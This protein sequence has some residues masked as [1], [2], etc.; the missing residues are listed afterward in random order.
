MFWNN[1]MK[2][3]TFSYDD[4]V[5]QDERLL[6]IFNKYNLKCTFNINSGIQTGANRF[7]KNNIP[8]R[9]MN[10]N[11]LKELYKG[12]EIAVHTLTHPH[13]EELDEDTIYNEIMQDKIN[14]ERIFER[15]IRGMA[16]PFGTYNE[17]VIDIIRKCGIEYARTVMD[18]GNFDIQDN[19]MELKATCHHKNKDLMKLAKEFAELKPDKPQLLYVWGHSYE[20]D[21]DDNWKV[22]EEFCEYISGHEDIFYGTNEEVLLERKKL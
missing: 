7:E 16:Y 14:L 19:L 10:I 12:H 8:I 18:A 21:V 22:I 2:A 20:F 1:K 13:L 9:R 15:N 4:G 5:C 11:G 3:L 6:K 17:T